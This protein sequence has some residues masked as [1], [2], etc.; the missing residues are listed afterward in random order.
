[1]AGRSGAAS[2]VFI[3]YLAQIVNSG[4]ALGS[5]YGLMAIGFALIFSS[6]RLINFAQ[7]E[8]LLIGGLTLQ[9]L[10]LVLHLS[11]L[12]ALTAAA[13]F[14]FVLGHLLYA[15]TLGVGIKASPLHQLMLTV[16][17]TCLAGGGHLMGQK[18]DHLPS[19]P[20]PRSAWACFF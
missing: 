12:A 13:L 16:A 18:P 4:L 17:A 19:F 15:T 8:L 6:S 1:M 9:S 3:Q 7:G 11:P 14:G 5:V 2:Q 20:C 10:T